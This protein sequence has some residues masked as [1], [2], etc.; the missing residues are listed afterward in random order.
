MALYT[1]PYDIADYL[2]SDEMIAAYLTEAFEA[3]DPREVIQALGDVTRARGGVERLSRLTGIGAEELSNALSKT[4][5][6]EYATI[7][8]VVHALGVKLSATIDP[9]HPVAA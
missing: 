1:E 5:K 7:H 9:Q 3:D 6:P 8:K 4:G 2:D